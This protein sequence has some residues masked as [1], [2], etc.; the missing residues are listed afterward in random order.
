[1][2]PNVTKITLNELTLFFFILAMTREFLGKFFMFIASEFQIE[3][4]LMIFEKF[5]KRFA[6]FILVFFISVNDLIFIKN[7][8]LEIK[9]GQNFN[10]QIIKIQT[11][12]P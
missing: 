3:K 6:Q 1:M 4:L 7:L 9:F 8:I 2:V 12:I 5:V 10:F 11:K